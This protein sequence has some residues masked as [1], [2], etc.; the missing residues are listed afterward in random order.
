MDYRTEEDSMGKLKIPADAYYGIHTLR[1][2]NN[3]NISSLRWHPNFIQAIAQIKIACSKANL[4]L[5]L[6]AKKKSDAIVQACEE[7]ISGKFEKEFPLDV[8]QSGSGTSTHMNINEVIAN[9]ACEILGGK[10]GEKNIVHPNDDVNKGQSTNDVIPT[11]IRVSSIMMLDNMQK[12]LWLLQNSLKKKSKEFATVLKS[13]RTHLQDAVPITLGQEF[14]AYAAAMEKHISRIDDTKKYL[15][16]LPIGGNAVGTGLN[17]LKDFKKLIV[18]NLNKSTGKNFVQANDGIEGVQFLT[19][20]ATLSSAIKL[21]FI[22]MN[23][24]ANDLRLLSSGPNT[25]F[26]EI[27]LPDIEPGSSIMPGKVNPNIPEIVNM[28]YCHIVGNDATISTACTN[29]NLELNTHMP[30]I[31]WTIIDS[32]EILSNTAKTFA[33]GCIDG[34]TANKERCEQY[35]SSSMALATALN[36]YIGYDKAAMLVKESQK[37]KKTVKTLALEKKLLTKSELDKILDPKNLTG[38][39]MK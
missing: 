11:A 12:N 6:L 28:A 38:P 21:A 18:R 35:V 23:K 27:N 2:L 9:R 39:N 20:I 33:V 26:G 22:D 25:G 10:K 34:I 19:D 15:L 5:G 14:G 13:G 4:E 36:P 17:T 32:I 1:S 16:Q 37:T 31:A 30:I 3:F 7:I 29:G 24:I 8:F